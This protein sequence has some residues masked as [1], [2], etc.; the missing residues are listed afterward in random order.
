MSEINK[1]DQRF[2][3][4]AKLVSTWSK[5]PSTKVG[6]VIVRPDRT[7]SSVGFNGF[8]LGV[9]D[10]PDRLEDRDIKYK[11]V[12]HAEENACIFANE[13]LDDHTIYVYPFPPCSCCAGTIIQNRIKRVVAF[14]GPKQKAR[15]ESDNRFNFDLTTEMFQETGT[16]LE[17]IYV[18]EDF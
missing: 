9:H 16:Q 17:I 18:G 8:P 6:A 4:M 1:W 10:M 12:K 3:Q 14:V 11:M 5:D 2:G 7:V 15:M 13:R